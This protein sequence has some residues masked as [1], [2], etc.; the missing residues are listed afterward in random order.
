M[1]LILS[2]EMRKAA[3]SLS[4]GCR[5]WLR[6][7]R[8]RGEKSSKCET[9]SKGKIVPNNKQWPRQIDGR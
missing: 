5:R 1:A 7:L 6:Y 4:F 3:L 9:F 8:A 2:F